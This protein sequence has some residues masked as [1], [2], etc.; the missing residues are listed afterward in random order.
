MKSHIVIATLVLAT[1]GA[2]AQAPQKSA[3]DCGVEP[4]GKYVDLSFRQFDQTMDGGWRVFG[5]KK[6]CEAAAADLIAQYHEK[7]RRDVDGLDWHEGQLRAAAGQTARAIE[8]FKNILAADK[9][10]PPE[11]RSDANILYHEATIAF[12]EG[13]RKTLEAKRAE[14]AILPMPDGMAEGLAKF[15]ERY[16]GQPAPE[17]PLNLGVVDRLIK[18][19]GKPYAEA[20]GDCGPGSTGSKP[21]TP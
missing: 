19:F 14:L 6:G 11:H 21:S 9:A 16:P 4:L 1:A 5:N 17:W 13:D 10:E 3:A 12:L 2:H 7:L 15:K 18:C 8:L 20:Y